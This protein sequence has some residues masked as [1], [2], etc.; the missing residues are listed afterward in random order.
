MNL[1]TLYGKNLVN[2]WGAVVVLVEKKNGFVL[3]TIIYRDRHGVTRMGKFRDKM[4][5]K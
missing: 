3:K 5:G 1:T 4:E 2:K